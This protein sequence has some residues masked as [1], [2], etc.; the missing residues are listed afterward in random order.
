MKCSAIGALLLAAATTAQAQT[1]AGALPSNLQEETTVRRIQWPVTIEPRVPGG[2]DDLLSEDIRV[3]EDGVEVEVD[4][5]ETRPL[6]TIHAVVID[7]SGS[8]DARLGAAKKAAL[9]YLERLP[10]GEPAMLATFSDNLVLNTPLTTDRE[11]LLRAMKKIEPRAFTALNDAIHYTVSY[12]AQ[13]PERKVLVLITDGCD[14]ASLTRH[15]LDDVVRMAGETPNLTVFPIGIDLPARCDGPLATPGYIG[16]PVQPLQ[17]LATNSGGHLYRTKE[18]AALGMVFDEI[19]ERLQKEG[20]V[21]Y[22]PLAHGR[23]KKDVAGED[24]RRRVKIESLRSKRCKITSSGPLTRMEYASGAAVRTVQPLVAGAEGTILYRDWWGPKSDD[25]PVGRL[26]LDDHA[27]HGHGADLDRERGALYSATAFHLGERYIS[28]TDR[29]VRIQRRSFTV[30]V[31]PFDWVRSSM[32]DPESVLLY[33]LQGD[34]V[35]FLPWPDP[36]GRRQRARR[37]FGEN[38]VHGQTMLEIREAVGRGLFTYPGYREFAYRRTQEAYRE[39]MDQVLEHSKAIR[40]LSAPEREKLAQAIQ[41][42]QPE[43]SGGQLQQYLA[44][45]LGDIPAYELVV[46]FEGWAANAVLDTDVAEPTAVFLLDLIDT[47]WERLG[48]WFP[49]PTQVRIVAPLV[50]AYD[51]SRDQIGFF[52]ILLPEVAVVGPPPNLVPER[53]L[54][55]TFL[56]HLTEVTGGRD[57]WPRGVR[58]QDLSYYW[59]KR[60]DRRRIIRGARKRKLIPHDIHWR[61]V[62]MV[63]MTLGPDGS[64]KLP[65]TVLWDPKPKRPDSPP[66]PICV[67]LGDPTALPSGTWVE[68]LRDS[69]L[70]IVPECRIETEG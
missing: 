36:E 1:P 23:G 19:F 18:T 68:D 15:S 54:G 56:R 52:R 53:P 69:I 62:P 44:E 41:A 37:V 16:G 7:N 66:P 40:S 60:K 10:A 17:K 21:A 61:K 8:M 59:D 33:L 34:A 9:A 29:K 28:E 12:L 46:G 11:I 58:M 3:R 26:V 70:D 50:P 27:M 6:P 4:G 13:R 65:V 30:D 42:Q 67:D 25:D 43:P 31:P 63:A 20:H 55:L 51:E 35:P 39:E 57:A 5:I 24:R 2:C 32:K 14:S 45:W 49:P 22:R 48:T 64:D 47:K 38:W